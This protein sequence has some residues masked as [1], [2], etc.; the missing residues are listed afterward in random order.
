M[1]LDVCLWDAR[2]LYIAITRSRKYGV[3]G[4]IWG[5]GELGTP[6]YNRT[7]WFRVGKGY[8]CRTARRCPLGAAA[9]L[10]P[11]PFGPHAAGYKY[12]IQNKK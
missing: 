7:S 11:W 3:R 10:L 1:L 5:E 8:T 12:K 9:L 2:L 4:G 6:Y